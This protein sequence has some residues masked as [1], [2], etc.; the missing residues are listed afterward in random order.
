MRTKSSIIKP[1][2]EK[3]MED[4]IEKVF[5]SPE[6]LNK[7]LDETDFDLFHDRPR[8]E[9]F[10]LLRTNKKKEEEK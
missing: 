5:S 10:P 9:Y 7:F 1:A 6:N 4:Y 3:E 8:E 2:W